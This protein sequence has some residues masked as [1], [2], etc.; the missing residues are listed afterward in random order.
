MAGVTY[1]LAYL[2]ARAKDLR[3]A[4]EKYE[5]LIRKYPKSS[6]AAEAQFVIAEIYEAQ[7]QFTKAA[8][9]F[10]AMKKFKKDEQT[11]RAIINA[12]T[13]YQSLKDYEKTIVSLKAL[14]K[15]FPKHEASP[16]AYLKIGD[17][18]KEM[19]NLPGA[20][21]QYTGFIKHKTYKKKKRMVLEANVKAGITLY[22][23][24]KVKNRVRAMRYFEAAA[25][26][27]AK[28]SNEDKAK[29]REFAAQSAF[30]ISQYG[31]Y[32]FNNFPID[33]RNFYR[34]VN[35]LEKKA[36]IH[37]EVEA[38][39]HKCIGI[40]SR[41][42]AAAAYYQ[43]GLIYHEFA[44][45]LFA[46]PLPDGLSEDEKDM[47]RAELEDRFA[48]PLEEKARANFKQA[49]LM[50]HKLGV[51]SEWS[52]KSG[53]MAAKLTPQDFPIDGEELVSTTRTKDTL[54]STSFIRSL[55]RGDIEVD[56][57]TLV[58]EKKQEEALEE[59]KKDEGGGGGG[60][61]TKGKA[62]VAG[63]KAP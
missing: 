44:E 54:M 16:R 32:D 61:G 1:T 56:F 63:K 17:F 11:P 35:S 52:K 60:E 29:S 42:W 7:T 31:Y 37:Q 38:L 50:A 45:T 26:S 46:L 24:N 9:A 19:G 27:F 53:I 34:M 51:Y 22:E 15:L 4:I 2:Y 5:E 10:M 30:Y 57:V 58:G 8:E 59:E 18:R 41:Y 14:L 33:T 3:R 39:Y 48:A 25:K 23:Q 36:K 62:P 20:Y 43:V 13:I 12:A 6:K 47:Y 55:R 28:M 49:I 40:K 21:K